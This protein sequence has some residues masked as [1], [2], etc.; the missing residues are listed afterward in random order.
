MSAYDAAPSED[1]GAEAN[2]T[3]REIASTVPPAEYKR[4]GDKGVRN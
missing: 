4:S 1:S 2:D 3:R